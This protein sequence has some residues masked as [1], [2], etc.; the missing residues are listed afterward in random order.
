MKYYQTQLDIQQAQD[1]IILE[2]N[3]AL[4]QFPKA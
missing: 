1:L 3:K 4:A 2:F